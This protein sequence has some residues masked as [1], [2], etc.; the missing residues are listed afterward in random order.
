VRA[1]LSLPPV[2]VPAYPCTWVQVLPVAGGAEVSLWERPLAAPGH[3][4]VVERA[5]MRGRRAPA[6]PAPARMVVSAL[7]LP[8]PGPLRPDWTPGAAAAA[9][10]DDPLGSQRWSGLPAAADPR[11]GDRSG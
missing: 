2:F 11:S 8:R 6:R 1:W 7:A 9:A 10:T 5:V 3:L 4:S